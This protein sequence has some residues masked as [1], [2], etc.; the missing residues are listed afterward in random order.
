MLCPANYEVK[1]GPSSHEFRR[2]FDAVI[3]ELAAAGVLTTV[4][5]PKKVTLVNEAAC[6]VSVN[7]LTSTVF[8]DFIADTA[9]V[10]PTELSII[11][12][13]FRDSYNDLIETFCDPIF[14]NVV[15]ARVSEENLPVS[16][17]VSRV[18]FT[19]RI[20]GRCRGCEKGTRIFAADGRVSNDVEHYL[21]KNDLCSCVTGNPE[22]QGATV[23][24]FEALAV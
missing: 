7:S 17:T 2:S 6:S 4:E 1:S 14:R 24:E 9:L 19:F 20:D 10:T 13:V 12:Q 22:K 3:E 5:D 15:G 8:V 11:E 18:Q 16:S 21:A 23:G